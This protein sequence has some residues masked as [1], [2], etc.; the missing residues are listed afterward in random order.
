MSKTVTLR[1]D[2]AVY[3]RFKLLAKDDNR[4]LSNYIETAALRFVE[5]NEYVDE[6]EMSEINSNADLNKSLKKGLNDAT[7]QRGKFV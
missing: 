1:L 6:F 7:S 2:E 5:E 4:P 3:N